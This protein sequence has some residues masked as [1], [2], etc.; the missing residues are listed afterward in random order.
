MIEVEEQEQHSVPAKLQCISIES[1]LALIF[2]TLV[3]LLMPVKWEQNSERRRTYCKNW[4]SLLSAWF[5][6][7]F[8]CTSLCSAHMLKSHVKDKK[9]RLYDPI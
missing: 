7:S 5:C 6:A 2:D 3:S 4:L 8:T 9:K 1:E